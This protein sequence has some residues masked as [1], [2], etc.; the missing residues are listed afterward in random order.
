MR[1]VVPLCFVAIWVVLSCQHD[2]EQPADLYYPRVKQIIETRCTSSCH[3]PSQGLPQGL[4]VILETD[5][6]IVAHAA[7]IK[8][9]VADPVSPTNHRMPPEGDT[10][11]AEQIAIVV[12]WFDRG[13]TTNVCPLNGP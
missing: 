5:G 10:L 13:G 6:D 11:N 9:A 2:V 7:G 12:E 8:A 4:P 3:A 1:N